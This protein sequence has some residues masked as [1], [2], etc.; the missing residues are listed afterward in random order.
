MYIDMYA[1]GTIRGGWGYTTGRVVHPQMW[2]QA[3]VDRA[4]CIGIVKCVRSISSA[5]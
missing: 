3:L 1:G 4:A 2:A 5:H